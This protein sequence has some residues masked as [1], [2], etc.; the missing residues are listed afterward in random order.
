[1]SEEP[2]EFIVSFPIF[3]PFRRTNLSFR[4]S[5]Y[6]KLKKMN[7]RF[8]PKYKPVVAEL[9]QFLFCSAVTENQEYLEIAP[10]VEFEDQVDK[11]YKK[12]SEKTLKELKS[13]YKNDPELKNSIEAFKQ[14]FKIHDSEARQNLEKIEQLPQLIVEEIDRIFKNGSLIIWDLPGT[15]IDRIIAGYEKI[16]R[17]G[18]SIAEAD[19]ASVSDELTLATFGK[20]HVPCLLRQIQNISSSLSELIQKIDVYNEGLLSFLDENERFAMAEVA[21]VFLGKVLGI[22]EPLNLAERQLKRYLNLEA[23][24]QAEGANIKSDFISQIY[25]K[26][27]NSAQARESIDL[28]EDIM[29]NISENGESIR[30]LL[31]RIENAKPNGKSSHLIDDFLNYTSNMYYHMEEFRFITET[32]QDIPSFTAMN[33]G[34]AIEG[35]ETEEVDV[36]EDTIIFMKDI[37]KT[38]PMINSTV[39]ALRGVDLEIKRGEFVAIMGPSGSGKTTLLNIMSGLDKP[40][41]GIIISDGLDLIKAKEKEL[42]K[43]RREKAAFIYQSYNLLPVMSNRENVSLPADLGIKKDVGNTK[44][45]ADQ[46]LVDVGLEQYVKGKPLTLSGG[47][48]QRVTIARA[49]M[50]EPNI[51]FC[52]E[53]T[54]DLDSTTGMQIID[55]IE[56][57]HKAGATI[58]LVTHDKAVAN[59]A[60]R[61]INMEDGKIVSK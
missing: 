40:D 35:L 15:N 39:Y 43:Y 18:D 25:S 52:D 59:R 53:P 55:L 10:R 56:N 32:F 6:N 49:F 19:I 44:E 24:L 51:L 42:I 12:F 21:S 36:P 2:I 13:T 4:R 28:L 20:E 61:I 23:D 38:F 37:F 30:K 54:G 58:V 31:V 47:Q 48:Q 26:F 29:H 8:R 22:R 45:R 1:M 11:I 7:K 57:Y 14:M 46:L 3:K 41:R 50:N 9:N 17:E 27:I 33:Q 16:N 34:I 5:V 60:E